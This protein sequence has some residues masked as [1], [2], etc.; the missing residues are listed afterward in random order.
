VLVTACYN[1]T[2]N[3]IVLVTNY[4]QIILFYLLLKIHSNQY[5]YIS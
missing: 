5:C 4:S 3:H 2:Q 1:Y